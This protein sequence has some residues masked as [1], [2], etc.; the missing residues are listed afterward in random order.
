MKY[1]MITALFGG[2]AVPGPA[3]AQSAGRDLPMRQVQSA[4][5]VSADTITLLNGVRELSNGRVLVNDAGRRRLVLL[6]RSLAQT[7]VIAD[8]SASAPLRYGPR[9]SSVIPFDGDSTLFVDVAGPSFLV[10]D[11]D[12][13][14][15]RV[16][17]AP[18]SNDVPGMTVGSAGAPRIDRSG[19]IV[20]RSSLSP[21]FRAP[22]IGKAYVPPTV[23]DSAPLLRVDFDTRVADT[24]AWIRTAKIRIHTVFLPNGG[25]RLT[26]MVTPISTI[27][28][29]VALPD[30]S[31]AVLRGSDYH[32]DWIEP[33]GTRRSTKRM[34]F[35]WKPLDDEAKAALIDSTR[36]RIKA[37]A[38]SEAAAALAA[39]SGPR[40]ER[41]DGGHGGAASASVG[42]HGM[43]I[44]PVGVT[45][46]GSAPPQSAGK[47]PEG[48][49]L[50]EVVPASDL[51]D[52]Y[53]PIQRA[54]MMRAD[55]LG[56]LWVLPS[57]SS[58]AGRGLL[59]D[60]IDRD[61]TIV[62]RVRL[63]EGRTLEGFSADGALYLASYGAGGTRLERARIR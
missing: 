24:I 17:S 8:S 56:R 39:A 60:V 2:V 37:Q 52:Y 36:A 33:D 57:T 18:R 31:V 63:P 47:G 26:P 49:E 14:V 35:D 20:Y 1:F 50:P 3:A 34:P 45:S 40:R 38:E 48:P 19:R 9:A 6:D 51:P 13:R 44:M 16:M 12:G 5:A 41:N 62:E 21:S 61:G 46:D 7:Q 54:G 59:Y 28:D 22:V 25:V 42:G 11:A 53:P 43:T 4:E 15:A 23:A 55:P 10:L 30:G 27:D 29:W 58:Q 32:I